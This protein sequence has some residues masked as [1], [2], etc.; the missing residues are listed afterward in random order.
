[1]T[2][3]RAL[4]VVLATATISACAGLG[5]T[6][7]PTDAWIGVTRSEVE[8]RMGLASIQKPTSMGTRLTY[9]RGPYGRHTYIIDFDAHDRLV[10]WQQVLTEQQFQKILPGMTAGAVEDLIG[11][12]LEKTTLG[13]Q[14]G[15]VWSYRFETPFCIWFQVEIDISGVVRSAGHGIPPECARDDD[16]FGMR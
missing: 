2:P 6:Y 8:S 15:E 5:Y 12:S 9:A 7:G 1:M 11:P 4:L 13:R 10:Q 3:L 14:R 16:W